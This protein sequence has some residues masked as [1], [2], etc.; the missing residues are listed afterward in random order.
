MDAHVK[1]Y[2]ELMLAEAGPGGQYEHALL[3]VGGDHGV[4]GCV[5]VGLCV[6]M[7][8]WETARLYM[9]ITCVMCMAGGDAGRHRIDF[10]THE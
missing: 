4:W 8:S 10:K 6:C 1:S 9:R 7:I 3:L 5:C 2:V